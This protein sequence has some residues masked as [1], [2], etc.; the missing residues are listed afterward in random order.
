MTQDRIQICASYHP[1]VPVVGLIADE[2]LTLVVPSPRTYKPKYSAFR[3]VHADMFPHEP[4]Q[5]RGVRRITLRSD[6]TDIEQRRS[7]PEYSGDDLLR[8]P[9]ERSG[10]DR[11]D[12][13]V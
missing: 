10:V 8:I 12:I 11:R 9:G 5:V 6:R 13:D 4:I 1:V 7:S 3:H 2:K